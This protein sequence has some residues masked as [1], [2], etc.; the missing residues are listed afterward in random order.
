MSGKAHLVIALGLGLIAVVA[1]CETQKEL[2]PGEQYVYT[3]K[4]GD[5][6]LQAIAE[7]V[8]G[9]AGHASMIEKANPAMD[10]K[11]LKPGSKLI[12]PPMKTLE[13]KVIAP[14]ECARQAIY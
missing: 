13:G 4:E 9:D 11:A 6:S 2:A 12:V 8:Y 10:A 14:K 1:G 3:V 5:E 7:K